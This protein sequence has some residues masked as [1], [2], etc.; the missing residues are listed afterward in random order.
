MSL[1]LPEE[2]ANIREL[3]YS[4]NTIWGD[5]S[6]Y[7]LVKFDNESEISICTHVGR[8][9]T[10][11]LSIQTHIARDTSGELN[12]LTNVKTDDILV[13][14]YDTDGVL[15][16]NIEYKFFKRDYTV[17]VYDLVD[18][19]H[20]L[21]TSGISESGLIKVNL[22]TYDLQLDDEDFCINAWDSSRS[23]SQAYSVFFRYSAEL[24]SKEDRFKPYLIEKIY[25]GSAEVP[26]ILPTADFSILEE[27]CGLTLTSLSLDGDY[28]IATYKW[29]IYVDSVLIEHVESSSATV[30]EYAWP[31]MGTFTLVHEV[32]DTNGSSSSKSLNYTVTTC[33]Q[34]TGETIIIDNGSTYPVYIE[35]KIPRIKIK[36]VAIEH[37]NI[38]KPK[39]EIEIKAMQED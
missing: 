3:L 1:Q 26:P 12:V 14:Y 31:Y 25:S 15:V 13:Y 39:V 34:G 22:D 33:N 6:E 36:S 17:N 16:P 29:S 20:T 11:D 4:D 38:R 19:T 32:V 5:G 10:S 27:S 28:P 8:S 30:F 2:Y 7:S 18:S 23:E 24:Y 37:H 35:K 9:V 21:V